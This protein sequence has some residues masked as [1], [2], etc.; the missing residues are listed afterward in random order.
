MAE[1]VRNT[2]YNNNAQK[3]R[4]IIVAKKNAVMTKDAATKPAAKKEAAPKKA[5]AKKPATKKAAVATEATA[6]AKKAEIRANIEAQIVKF[7][8]AV[9]LAR[10][11]AK[12]E[13]KKKADDL[14]KD[15]AKESKLDF[16]AK[17]R[18]AADP[19]TEAL[20]LMY[21]PRLRVSVK[22]DK[23]TKL[24]VMTLVEDVQQ[25]DL[26]WL[27]KKIEGGIGVDKSWVSKAERMN[28]ALTEMANS[29]LGK[30]VQD[31]RA[32][33]RIKAEALAEEGFTTGES[34]G[35]N[36]ADEG[37]IADVK[38]VVGAMIGEAFAEEIKPEVGADGKVSAPKEVSYILMAHTSRDRKGGISTARV[39]TFVRSLADVCASLRFPDDESK[40]LKLKVGMQKK[41][42]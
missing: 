18:Q 37:I 12:D 32:V 39:N 25:I 30:P 38:K 42:K 22:E 35:L 28:M 24:D 21:Y 33:Y 23:E 20:R 4:K 6:E 15:Y 41:Q 5:T 40:K 19:M 34:T 29:T 14:C 1:C 8:N 16:A 36:A 11:K 13:A 17:C 27:H 31:V 10:G 7:N 3:E 26:D 9:M 2:H